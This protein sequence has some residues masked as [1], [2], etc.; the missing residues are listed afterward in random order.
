MPRCVACEKP[1]AG[2]TGRLWT[3]VAQARVQ[4]QLQVAVGRRGEQPGR[5][6]TLSIRFREVSLAA[7]TRQAQ[8]P[9]LRLWAIEAR[10]RRAPKGATP[11][12]WCLLTTLPVTTI[13]AALEKVAWYAQRWQIEVLHKVLKSGCQIEQRQL[14]TATRLERALAVDLVVAWRLLALCKSAREAPDAAVSAWLEQAEWEALYCQVHQRT[15]PPKSPPTVRQAV[16]WIAGL[17]G[18]MGRK[19]DG[20]PGPVT[21]WRGLQR[22]HD[23]TAMWRLFHDKK[24]RHKCG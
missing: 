10:E 2:E 23:L 22:L 21:L 19:S 15:V 12:R 4:G 17:G 11:I 6:A 3:A 5:L 24:R 20:E 7:P 18:F 14:H 9:P 8:Q 1:F 16:R 13:A